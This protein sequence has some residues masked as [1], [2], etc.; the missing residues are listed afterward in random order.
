MHCLWLLTVKF[1][2]AKCV[3]GKACAWVETFWS[4]IGE[5]EGNVASF[6]GFLPSSFWPHAK[7]E[8]KKGLGIEQ[9]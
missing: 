5:V 3:G 1:K 4:G 7:S 2:Y 8:E 9:G 6:Q